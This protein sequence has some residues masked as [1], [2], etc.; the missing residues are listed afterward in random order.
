[1][2]FYRLTTLH[3]LPACISV[4]FCKSYFKLSIKKIIPL[5]FCLTYDYDRYSSSYTSYVLKPSTHWMD[6]IGEQ[7]VVG[8]TSWIFP[9]SAGTALGN[10]SRNGIL[11]LAYFF[12][13]REIYWMD[14]LPF[15][16]LSLR[17]GTNLWVLIA[18]TGYPNVHW[19]N[20]QGIKDL[21][22]KTGAL[23][24]VPLL[25][26]PISCWWTPKNIL[27]TG[28]LMSVHSQTLATP[29]N[30]VSHCPMQRLY[31]EP[32][33][34]SFQGKTV[35]MLRQMY[36]FIWWLYV[37]LFSWKWLADLNMAGGVT[38]VFK[39]SIQLCTNRGNV[40]SS[41]PIYISFIFSF[42]LLY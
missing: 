34:I 13:H 33:E 9:V 22:I 29:L 24:D 2:T 18:K 10:A 42:A 5:C 38:R 20:G 1:M 28:E 37:V 11:F 35:R 19:W 32:V 36:V 6:Q 3:P 25:G 15:T 39:D 8:L 7:M 41:F 16:A 30:L 12:R 26:S 27:G 23:A 17:P 4:Y 40:T 21:P 14:F 31:W